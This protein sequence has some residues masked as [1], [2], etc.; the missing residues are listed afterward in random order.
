MFGGIAQIDREPGGAGVE[1]RIAIAGPLT[2]LGLAALFAG[3]WLLARGVA[4]VAAPAIWLAR[5]KTA[6]AK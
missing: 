5:I 3:A 1:F 2:S 4:L 6:A